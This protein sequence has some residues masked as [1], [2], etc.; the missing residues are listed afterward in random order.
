MR[1]AAVFAMLAASVVSASAATLTEI[2]GR[3]LVSKGSGFVPAAKGVFLSPGDRVVVEGQGTATIQFT[4]GCSHPLSSGTIFTVTKASPCSANIPEA[5]K[6]RNRM[7]QTVTDT[8]VIPTPVVIGGLLIGGGVAAIAISQSGGGNSG[9][10]S[11]PKQ[12]P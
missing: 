9:S 7:G 2:N 1:I 3:A 5:E 11:Q 12:S 8:P 6:F 10:G 4:D